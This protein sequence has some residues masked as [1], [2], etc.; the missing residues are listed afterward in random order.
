MADLSKNEWRDFEK[1]LFELISKEIG[2]VE[3]I[4]NV[5]AVLTDAQNDGGYD[6][7]YEIPLNKNLSNDSYRILFEAKLRSKGENDLP[8]QDFSKALIIAINKAAD[9]LIIG[10]N[11]HFSDNTLFQLKEFER[12]THL[13]IEVLTGIDIK[14]WLELNKIDIHFSTSLLNL[15]EQTKEKKSRT[16]NNLSD[17]KN[18]IET[19]RGKN[20][21]IGE[22]RKIDIKLAEN[23]IL[24]ENKSI[25]IEGEAGIGKSFF[26]HVLEQDIAPCISIVA[27]D[28]KVYTTSRTLFLEIVKQIW[29]LSDEV[30]NSIDNSGFMEA[31]SYIGNHRVD[32][33]ICRSVAEAFGKNDCEYIENASIFNS[34]LLRYLKELF[35]VLRERGK[36]II[37][38]A[39]CNSATPEVLEFIL[40]MVADLFQTL[41]FAIE[42]RTSYY[43]DVNMSVEQWET[44]VKKFENLGSFLDIFKMEKWS[45]GEAGTFLAAKYDGELDINARKYILSQTQKTPLYIDTYASYLRITGVLRNVPLHLQEKELQRLYIDNNTQL[46]GLLIKAVCSDAE[47][48]CDYLAILDIFDGQINENQIRP[49]LKDYEKERT[50]SLVKAGLI[51]FEDTTIR[52]RHLLYLDYMKKHQSDYI[53]NARLQSIALIILENLDSYPEYNDRWYTALINVLEIL[54]KRKR[55]SN[56][57][58]AFAQRLYQ[59]GQYYLCDLYIR[60][61]YLAFNYN[62]NL[63][64]FHN[65]R[66]LELMIHVNYYLKDKKSDAMDALLNELEASVTLG[67]YSMSNSEEGCHLICTG[68]MILSRYAHISGKF[69]TELNYIKKA[70]SFSEQHNDICPITDIT[71]IWVEY[72]IAVK[73]VNGLK[74]FI[75]ILEEKEKEYPEAYDIKYTLNSALYQKYAINDPDCAEI[76]LNNNVAIEDK[77]AIPEIYHNRVHIA[78]NLLH[79]KQYDLVQS[80]AITLMNKVID[81]GLKNEAGRLANIIG[82]SFLAQK[83]QNRK[84]AREYFEYGIRIYKGSNY[85]SYL[86]PLLFNYIVLNEIEGDSEATIMLIQELVEILSHFKKEINTLDLKYIAFPKIL[87]AYLLLL[88]ML[89]GYEK[90]DKYRATAE[91]LMNELLSGISNEAITKYAFGKKHFPKSMLEQTTYCHGGIFLITY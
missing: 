15:I 43:I 55:I 23:S 2:L 6:G 13:H 39:N 89:K 27:L 54:N 66:I 60:K 34:A 88:R 28:L 21:L 17:I 16:L 49:I 46:I 84:L 20:S 38:I 87:V 41:Q 56:D 62:D 48:N 82:C 14:K 7:I 26:I 4:S 80:Y 76:Y 63:D 75:Q 72:S 68:Y 1:L 44:Y 19:A 22:K 51:E 74:S 67:Q 70:A 47:Q 3:N 71:T 45:D 73:E 91:S 29:N 79:Q 57:A 11:L 53:G 5:T 78:N 85:V 58:Y 65:L 83:R 32:A 18:F 25:L 52:I 10:T 81:M 40:Q 90:K 9:T 61:A 77:M 36:Y 24:A 86:W 12:R 8:L 59:K 33:S 37:R 42:L 50:D 35:I 31:I 69:D 64:E 30:V